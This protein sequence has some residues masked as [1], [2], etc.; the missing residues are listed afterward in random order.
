MGPQRRQNLVLNDVDYHESLKGFSKVDT[1]SDLHFKY[2]SLQKH[3]TKCVFF[4]N[5]FGYS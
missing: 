2:I 4:A 1:W 3:L 5:E